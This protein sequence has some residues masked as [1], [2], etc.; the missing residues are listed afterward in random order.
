MDV[1]H[2]RE[3]V[4]RALDDYVSGPDASTLATARVGAS[5]AMLALLQIRT[6]SRVRIRVRAALLPRSIWGRILAP[7]SRAG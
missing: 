5:D 4:R 2:R 3:L 6:Q 7:F 1:A